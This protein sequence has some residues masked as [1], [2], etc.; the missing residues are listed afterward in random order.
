VSASK[1][2]RLAVALLLALIPACGGGGGG[3]DDGDDTE[4]PV[5]FEI[6]EI[7]PFDGEINVNQYEWIR[8]RFTRRLEVSSLPGSFTLVGP[9]GVVDGG[10]YIANEDTLVQFRPTTPFEVATTYT[11]TVRESVAS[12]DGDLLG[13]SRS[14]E[15]TT[16]VVPTPR[17]IRSEDFKPTFGTMSTG[18]SQH[19]A[20][21]LDDDTVLVAGGFIDASRTTGKAEIYD[22]EEFSFSP[23][24][25]AM[26]NARA[27]H[28]ATKLLDGR[29]LIVGGLASGGT[30]ALATCEIYDPDQQSFN[31]T[32]ELRHVRAYHTASLL[33]DGR[34]LVCGGLYFDQDGNWIDLA[35][36]EIY[37][38][39]TGT[40]TELPATMVAD[41]SFH[42]AS[43]LAD[44]RVLLIGGNVNRSAEIFDPKTETFSRTGGDTVSSRS[45]HTV[46]E[47]PN[48]VLLVSGGGDKRGELYI[49]AEDR[50]EPTSNQ[51]AWDRYY[52]TATTTPGGG[53]LVLGGTHFGDQNI[54]ILASM[55]HYWQGAGA[56][57]S[58]LQVP[59]TLSIGLSGHTATVLSDGST[60]FCGGINSDWTQPELATALLFRQ[61]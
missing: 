14:F 60:L 10:L 52:A 26:T 17:P 13:A 44:G 43:T 8:V 30:V 18:R 46:C 23:L 1:L 34:V 35:R 11:L 61:D 21:L 38:P 27:R 12:T 58:Y 6:E 53:V 22:P 36:A 50:F 20:T 9:D 54:L 29:V 45:G 49:P 42:T 39:A 33:P 55:E 41:R 56:N 57:G 47:L 19:T 25:A 7:R 48:G 15:F 2:N 24:T 28:T 32:G 16:S 59:L 3:G 31:A 40:W 4:K 5:P 51:G 37:D